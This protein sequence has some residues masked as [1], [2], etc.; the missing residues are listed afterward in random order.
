M[1]KKNVMYFPRVSVI[2]P[3]YNVEKYIKRTIESIIHQTYEKLDIIIVN[4]G[5][6]DG[7]GE[8]CEKYANQDSRIRLFNQDNQGLSEARNK[9]INNAEGEYIVFIDGDDFIHPQ[10]IELLL[11]SLLDN[12][13]DISVCSYEKTYENNTFDLPLCKEEKITKYKCYSFEEAIGCLFNSNTYVTFTV[14]WNKLYRREIFDDIRY[15]KGRIHEDEF[16]IYRIFSNANKVVYI[17]NKL[18][19][20]LQRDG[21]IMSEPFSVKRFDKIVA[22]Q[23]RADFL[24]ERHIYEFQA[25]NTYLYQY[26]SYLLKYLEV[27][28]RNREYY[29][30]KKGALRYCK[31]YMKHLP[32]FDRIKIFFKLLF[33]K[34]SYIFIGY[35][36]CL[37]DSRR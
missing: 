8:I 24:L 34:M 7:T 21:S 14:A 29:L 16:V 12:S 3:V 5:S 20:Y 15:P 9:G 13:A 19:F 6:L 10:M 27:F 17:D 4:D 30:A 37:R 26:Y 22:Y 1:N 36:Q 2:V 32:F 33:P 35:V 23:E 18:Y 11:K 28:G 31:K 25:V